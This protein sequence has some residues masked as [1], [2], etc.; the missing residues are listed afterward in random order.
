[1]V[2]E[3]KVNVLMVDD[4]PAS[5]AAMDAVLEDQRY[6]LVRATSG[7]EALRLL[8]KENFALILMDVQMPSMNG[9]ETARI[10]QQ[11][12]RNRHIPII[13]LRA[14]ERAASIS[15]RAIPRA[16]WTTL[17]KPVDP[18]ILRAKV[19]VFIIFL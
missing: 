10:I 1:M 4:S 13:F 14:T 8:L 2:A 19:A 16:R 11:R 6:N 7:N 12:A 15:L 17:L 9:F 5:L 18:D 3:N